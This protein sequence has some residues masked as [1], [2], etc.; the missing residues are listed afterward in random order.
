MW[1]S[2]IL[3]AWYRY[4]MW[5]LKKFENKFFIPAG[6]DFHTRHPFTGYLR[7]IKLILICIRWRSMLDPEINNTKVL[8]RCSKISWAEN[9]RMVDIEINAWSSI[10]LNLETNLILYFYPEK[11]IKFNQ[12]E[13]PIRSREIWNFASLLR[14]I[15][16]NGRDSLILKNRFWCFCTTSK[17]EWIK[18]EIKSVH[19]GYSD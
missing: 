19:I 2:L 5:A 12:S 16:R 13:S 18:Q 15:Y 8:I 10:F 17:K 4:P 11:W 9:F 14:L 6:C 7:E 3:N 1:I